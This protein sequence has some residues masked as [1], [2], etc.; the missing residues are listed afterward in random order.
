MSTDLES[1]LWTVEGD[2]GTIE[3]VIMNMVVNARDAMPE[4]GRIAIRTENVSVDKEYCHTHSE[5]RPGEFMCV[6]VVDTGLGI[7]PAIIDRIFEP[8][9]TTKGPGKGSGMGLSV[10]YGIVKQHGGWVTVESSPGNGAAFRVYLPAASVSVEEEWQGPLPLAET[11]RGR[12]ERIL[13]VEDEESVRE[14][15]TRALTRDGYTIHA[16]QDVQSALEA[17]EKEGRDFALVF[18]DVVLPDGRGPILVERI[19]ELKP[20]VGVLLASGYASDKSD[21]QLIQ[22]RAYPYLQKPYSLS[23]LLAAVRRVLGAR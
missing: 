4:G 6:S 11:P 15:V 18:S 23:E 2:A 8:F 3:Q 1:G 9:F 17:F 16:V 22:K 13:L 19:L 20:D 10:V 5:A 12:G 21:W 7:D 14:F